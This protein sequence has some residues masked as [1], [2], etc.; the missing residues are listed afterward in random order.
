MSDVIY[1]CVELAEPE[2]KTLDLWLKDLTLPGNG[3]S[4]TWGEHVT[5]EFKPDN[6]AVEALEA[7][8]SFESSNVAVKVVSFAEDRHCHAFGVEFL[9]PYMAEMCKNK[10][11][12]ITMWNS[13]FVKPSYA[14]T[15]FDPNPVDGVN[16]TEIDGPIVLGFV[17]IR[18]KN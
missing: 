9:N 7:I 17:S 10:Q 14:N 1:T 13:Q 5:L 6:E 3:F 11:P 8:G 12:H 15:L 2:Q 18:R 16:V 4:Q